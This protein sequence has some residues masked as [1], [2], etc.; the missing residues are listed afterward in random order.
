MTPST[1]MT[2]RSMTIDD[3]EASGVRP[4]EIKGL[5]ILRESYSPFREH[6]DEPE[7]QRLNFLRW[8]I[9]RSSNSAKHN[10]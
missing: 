8:R 3:L 10:S 7:F 4:E 5:I 1:M 6:F 9:A 2:Q